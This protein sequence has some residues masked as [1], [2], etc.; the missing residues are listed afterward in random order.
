MANIDD[1]TQQVNSL[2]STVNSII[3]NSENIGNLT[4][5]SPIDGTEEI[6][7]QGE[8]KITVQQ[9]A[10]FYDDGVIIKMGILDYADLTTQTTPISITGG[11]GFVEITN[12][13]DGSNT[14]LTLPPT[15]VTNVW[16]GTLNTFDW[17]ELTSG[18]T[19][20]I[21]LDVE[22]TTTVANTEINIEL[23][24]GTGAGAYSIPFI[25]RINF[26]TAGTYPLNRYN[27]IYMRDSNTIDNGG[28]FK[29]SSDQDCTLK[30]NGWYCKINRR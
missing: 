13:S 19:V 16:D 8:E 4:L 20:D 3:S 26:K 29:I 7:I 15:G 17:S 2:T 6:P 18:D 14:F 12:D 21:R 11:S 27:G 30:V 10:D 1:L 24:L 28:V 5:K 22:V 23:F 25:T 9:I